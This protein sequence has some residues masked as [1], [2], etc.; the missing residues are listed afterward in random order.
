ML[1]LCLV[2]GVGAVFSA[3]PTDAQG[4]FLRGDC[5]QDAKIDSSDAIFGLIFFFLGGEEPICLAAC[6]MDNDAR[7]DFSDS[8]LTLT[9]LFL[10]GFDP[11]PPH[12]DEGVDPNPDGLGCLNGDL[13]LRDLRVVPDRMIFY[14]IGESRALSVVGTDVEGALRQLSTAHSTRYS[15]NPPNIAT[16]SGDGVVTALNLGQTVIT[17]TYRGT[18]VNVPVQVLAQADGSPRIEILS[19]ANSSIVF[20][21]EVVLFGRVS[22]PT[23]TVGI[24]GRRVEEG[25]DARG[26]FSSRQSLHPGK[27]SF[28]VA[29]TGIS[30]TTETTIT[31][32][33]ADP[34]DATVVG[35]DG[36]TFPTLPGFIVTE[37]DVTAPVV[38][39]SSPS[40]KATL[41]SVVVDVEGTVDDNSSRVLVN[42]LPAKVGGGNFIA[43][44]LGLTFGDNTITVIATDPS[45]N[46]S[47]DS[48]EVTVVG[49][50]VGISLDEP[51]G[52]ENFESFFSG[53]VAVVN[54]TPVTVHG[55]I[56]EDG[57]VGINGMPPQLSGLDFELD[58][59]L[60]PG[61]NRISA[62]VDYTESNSNPIRVADAKRVF[63]DND[64]PHLQW[65]T[66][67]PGFE[68]TAPTVIVGGR[69]SDDAAPFL[70]FSSLS[71]SINDTPI[72]H[73]EGRFALRLTL[74]E[75]AN[76]IIVRATDSFGRE[77]EERRVVTRVP[78]GN[79][80]IGAT[81]NDISVAPLD[82]SDPEPEV[83]IRDPL[84]NPRAGVPV[85][86]DMLLGDGHF[87]STRTTMVLTNADG[88][89]SVAFTAGAQA[90]PQIIRASS[91][92]VLGSPVYIVATVAPDAS[93]ERLVAR[94]RR[95]I[96]GI[97][98]QET[99][100]LVVRAFDRHGNVLPGTAVDFDSS[101]VPLF[102]GEIATTVFT[103]ED[104][105]AA[106]LA[107]FPGESGLTRVTAST[108]N[109]SRS[110]FTLDTRLPGTLEDTSLGGLILDNHG[111]PV[112]GVEIT[113][114]DFPEI[115]TASDKN[116]RFNLRNPPLGDLKFSFKASGFLD[117]FRELQVLQGTS[118]V[119]DA[120]VVLVPDDEEDTARTRSIFV[121]ETKGGTLTIPALNG[122]SLT[123]APGSVQFPDGSNSGHIRARSAALNELPTFVPD[124][125]GIEAAA[126][127]LP[128]GLGFDPPALLYSPTRSLP[129]GRDAHLY[130]FDSDSA[131]FTT[132]GRGIVD[133][134]G[135]RVHSLAAEGIARGGLYFFA[136][137]GPESGK[138]AAIEGSALGGAT[139]S[140]G[141]VSQHA[142]SA[143][144][145]VDVFAHSGEFVVEAVDLLVP[146]RGI[147]F[148]VRRRY[149]SRHDFQ[150]S[151]GWGW[152]HEYA[153]RRLIVVDNPGSGTVSPTSDILRANGLGRFDRYLYH[154]DS[155][156]Y[157]SPVGIFSRLFRSE[158]NFVERLPNGTR[159]FYHTLDGSPNAGRLFRIVDRN[160]NELNFQLTAG[161]L[162]EARD[163]LQRVITYGYNG[164]G[165]IESITDFT[166]RT[167]IYSYDAN[168]N[169]ETVTSPAVVNTPNG[170][171]FPDGKTTRYAYSN[172][173]SDLRLAHNLLSIYSP[174]ES[175]DAG[176]PYLTNSYVTDQSAPDFD[177]IRRQEWGGTNQSGVEAGGTF[178]FSYEIHTLPARDVSGAEFASF[179]AREGGITA[180]VDPCGLEEQVTWNQLGLPLST[181]TVT[182]SD[183]GPRDATRLQPEPGIDPPFLE[184][185]FLYTA[186]GLLL[187]KVLPRGNRSVFEYDLNGLLR[188]TR[189]LCTKETRFPAPGDNSPAIVVKR[190]HDPIFGQVV[191]E[192][193]P[194]FEG[195]EPV[196]T[197][198]ILDYQEDLSIST[199]STHMGISSTFLTDAI[200]SAGLVLGQGDLN[201]DGT[202]S[203]LS[204]NVLLVN[205]PAVT[206]PDGTEQVANEKMRWNGF[207]QRTMLT[208][209]EGRVTTETYHPENNPY[210]D[211]NARV[212]EGLDSS[213]GGFLAERI[214]DAADPTDPE[215]TGAAKVSTRFRYSPPGYLQEIEDAPGN[216]TLLF[217]NQ[218]GELIETRAPTPL[219]YRRRY[220][221]DTNGHVESFERSNATSNG[222]FPVPVAENLWL[223]QRFERDVL[224][225]IVL[226]GREI[227]A[228]EVGLPAEAVTRYSYDACGRLDGV[229]H[230]DGLV[231]EFV[232][233]ERGKV[234]LHRV[235]PGEGDA[236]PLLNTYLY[237]A[238]GNVVRWTR[239][240]DI[241]D[242]G[243]Q[244]VKSWQY[245]GFDRSVSETDEVGG[246]R[247]FVRDVWGNVVDES[248]L[249]T[250]GGK[251]PRDRTG[252]TNVLLNRKIREYDE[253][254]RLIRQ[255]GKHFGA[256]VP[257]DSPPTEELFFR[258]G[259]GRVLKHTDGD[260]E[261]L[262]QYDGA[263]LLRKKTEQ[264]IEEIFEY[265][266]KGHLVRQTKV[267]RANRD[268]LRSEV[269][270]EDFVETFTTVFVN[271]VLGRP[272][273]TIKPDGAVQRTFYDSRD[274]IIMSS[275]ALG[276]KVPAS[277]LPEL[278][279]VIDLLTSEQKDSVNQSGNQVIYQYDNLDRPTHVT[280]EMGRDGQ[281]QGPLDL[282]QPY[283]PD[284]LTEMSYTW[285]HGGKLLSWTTDRG[286]VTQLGYDGFGH[287]NSVT[288][289]EEQTIRLFRNDAGQP[290]EIHDR[291][292]SVIRQKF[293][294]LGRL[295]HREITRATTP[296][297]SVEGTTLQI[298]HWDGL[299]RVTLCYDD[300]NPDEIAD[301]SFT[302]F[303]YD[304]LG[305]IVHETQ[306]GFAVER[307]FDLNGRMKNLR[308]PGGRQ[309]TIDRHSDGHPLEI[310]DTGAT[311]TQDTF[312]G[313]R[314]LE[315]VY[316][317][318]V[319]L[320]FV[321]TPDEG[322]RG[323][324]RYDAAGKVFALV[325][326][327]KVFDEF[328]ETIVEEEI[329]HFNY[330]YD[331]SGRRLFDL[332]LHGFILRGDAYRYDSLG[333]MWRF[334]PDLRE[335]ATPPIVTERYNVF[336]FDGN[337]NA[338]LITK[339]FVDTSVNV[340][341]RDAWLDIGDTAIETD[342]SGNVIND[343]RDRFI[344]D[345]AGRLVRIEHGNSK[346]SRFH[347]DALG[348]EQPWIRRPTGR[349][350]RRAKSGAA[351][352]LIY[353]GPRVIEE[354][355]AQGSGLSI[356]RESIHDGQGKPLIAF[357]T[358]D[359]GLLET[360][361]LAHSAEGNIVALL[362]ETGLIRENIE[363]G[364][365]GTIEARSPGN[366]PLLSVGLYFFRGLP[367]N[368]ESGMHLVGA[369]FLSPKHWRFSSAVQV[370]EFGPARGSISPAPHLPLPAFKKH[371]L[372]PKSPTLPVR[373]HIEST[374]RML[375]PGS[376]DFNPYVFNLNDPVN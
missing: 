89:A 302:T 349:L 168:G 193:T 324:T 10:G 74:D 6:D 229:T 225:K 140:V 251:T 77:T 369:R 320:S 83:E 189:G 294:A 81:S 20:V 144:L 295:L 257:A 327:G 78:S 363:Y 34:D 116:G 355:G 365:F 11:P 368:Q 341:R 192:S 245:D 172:A 241:D 270:R 66:P 255:L 93:D 32:H 250:A 129:P 196:W 65:M 42:G 318:N 44:N 182:K 347:W 357:V 117:N 49:R 370:P 330:G 321:K 159:Y 84:G 174:A 141:H 272:L 374:G 202:V 273:V 102:S 223:T 54:T 274:N 165:R 73:V 142:D 155:D 263:G 150:G 231:E 85:L 358:D 372:E 290:V 149:E 126:W 151:L 24:A 106:A 356:K 306:S 61:L 56:D 118:N 222:G 312:I 178:V 134:A 5:N 278:T 286:G 158:D 75:G 7:A 148:T 114:V 364:V 309:V 13:P 230:P 252:T 97:A 82:L 130:G 303:S 115:V 41:T 169:L 157:I 160:N 203:G 239:P 281:G 86:F 191:R 201:G 311:Y 185:R 305:R 170:N 249:G 180:V 57:I 220:F 181:R 237:D 247:L 319:F 80:I 352:Q 132:R 177:H 167:V 199:L 92:A 131:A 33:R 128:E 71:L 31:I 35:P 298:F 261:S 266:T 200:E 179:L 217:F 2:V 96:L 240:T 113:V 198:R 21:S 76:D 205:H 14:E 195:D 376:L 123:I 289:P 276:V 62:T 226:E 288:D 215:A 124:F 277:T 145:G 342:T 188:Y 4:V 375:A 233:E 333:R 284:G 15:S 29:A 104:G 156:S 60:K 227:S 50:I 135:V 310:R 283:N 314:L 162:M 25:P 334:V 107:T 224:G 79:V 166:G 98:G 207:G 161:Q 63:L 210:G 367:F 332:R 361:Y 216:V 346:E 143:R 296:E 256:N 254:G 51:V 280:Y 111:Q 204:G 307:D 12:P 17:V 37:P 292:G 335:P 52:N 122:W 360:R 101:E 36:M 103:N 371:S 337:H 308:Y 127:I 163:S 329:Y 262:F 243:N 43:R 183:L 139:V 18:T 264:G 53:G 190:Q 297:F 108:P 265:D 291:N 138:T 87:N 133:E 68:T 339:D 343:G 59:A 19:P 30:G 153:D 345:F 313:N 154:S 373:S 259:T 208:D 209:T 121:S 350:T 3:T 269:P 359:N 304:S 212:E 152:E 325:W 9:H 316:S 235:H 109:G 299:G 353:D 323:P 315:R 234:Y 287:I 197:E 258:D 236:D 366:V 293:D 206:L 194:H 186:E 99:A 112:E 246:R 285:D 28:F 184:T 326:N 300:N 271:D 48:R 67:S 348:M 91:P 125:V 38:T 260:L 23:A 282:T 72:S 40:D 69:I 58:V 214:V 105:I 338:L 70:G 238:N 362:D 354:R 317:N 1:A 232:H 336:N 173:E 244:E 328:T 351:I 164:E 275:D 8:I 228:G 64:A 27:N 110:I 16:T 95:W 26:F 248:T 47:S 344:Y 331:R 218:L 175:G 22:D 100:H 55:T 46:Q 119:F 137:P 221:Y 187:E 45:G 147:D 94:G 211:G 136:L 90:G 301:D 267:E 120:P 171:D 146:G 340:D 176:V 213:T 219:S 39:V 88:R 253:R 242:N 322:V 279:D 268:P